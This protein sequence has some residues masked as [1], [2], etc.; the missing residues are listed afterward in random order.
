MGVKSLIFLLLVDV[1]RFWFYPLVVDI[2]VE[3]HLLHA[4]SSLAKQ[5]PKKTVLPDLFWSLSLKQK[6]H[7]RYFLNNKHI[8]KFISPFNSSKLV[9]KSSLKTF[10]RW[11]SSR[12]FSAFYV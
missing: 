7:S 4:Y 5:S 6:P 11:D 10:R 1:W 9:S 2:T 3:K 12:G 8:F